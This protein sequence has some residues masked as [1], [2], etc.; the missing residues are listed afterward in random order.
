DYQIGIGAQRQSFEQLAGA[1]QEGTLA[2]FPILLCNVLQQSRLSVN[3]NKPFGNLAHVGQGFLTARFSL[4]GSIT[5]GN[6]LELR[7]RILALD[8]EPIPLMAGLIKLMLQILDFRCESGEISPRQFSFQLRAVVA[9]PS[10]EQLSLQ[11]HQLLPQLFTFTLRSTQRHQLCHLGPQEVLS[12]FGA[13]AL[14]R[15]SFRQGNRL[16]GK[17]LQFTLKP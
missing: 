6:G 11:T 12:L 8:S 14:F 4:G 5:S 3:S 16:A 2:A 17:L 7:Q 10:L 15:K 1:R 9:F 13:N